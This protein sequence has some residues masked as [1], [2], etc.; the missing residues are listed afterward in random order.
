MPVLDEAARLRAG[1]AVSW[2]A[3]LAGS[4]VAVALS[5]VLIVLGTGIGFLGGHGKASAVLV[6]IW[7]IVTQW[8]SAAVGGFI[9]G[10]LRHRWLATHEHEVFFRD[11]AHGLAMWAVATVALA[12]ATAGALSKTAQHP[13]LSRMATLAPLGTM[14]H[15]PARTP[16]SA[17]HGADGDVE[18]AVTRL[19]PPVTVSTG[20]GSMDGRR[21]VAAIVAHGYEGGT[22]SSEDRALLSEI[23]TAWGASA[24]EAERRI[25]AL[26]DSMQEARDQAETMRRADAKAALFTTLS[27]LIGA[28]IAS[29]AGAIGGRMRDAH[30]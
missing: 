27:M 14:L 4:V 17:M 19:L 12:L 6:A 5:G 28:F 26:G 30:V 13:P 20:A 8:L 10:R 11:T 9:T 3:I 29:I 1:A 7:L 2:G 21:E 22:L 15:P 25:K 18:Y 16:D 24:G 23:L